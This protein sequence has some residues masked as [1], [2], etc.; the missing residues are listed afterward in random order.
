VNLSDR[1]PQADHD[2]RARNRQVT[3]H[4]HDHGEDE[5]AE[6]RRQRHKNACD[7]ATVSTRGTD[8]EGQTGQPD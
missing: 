2:V 7:A 1:V 4:G 3:R 5:Q 6:G 8:R